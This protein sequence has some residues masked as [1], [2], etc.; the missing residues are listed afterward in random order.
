MLVTPTARELTTSVMTRTQ[1]CM[2]TRI[3]GGQRHGSHRARPAHALGDR[4]L[5]LPFTMAG[6]PDSAG[7]GVGLIS[8]DRE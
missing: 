5:N 7:T 2:G 3:R 4:R 6:S 1:V 8:S